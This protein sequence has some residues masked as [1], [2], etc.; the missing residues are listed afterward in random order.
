L[1]ERGFEIAGTRPGRANVQDRKDLWFHHPLR[2][3][4]LELHWALYVPSLHVQADMRGLWLRSQAIEIAG[5]R[6]VTLGFEDTL[7]Y[8]CV[9]GAV[10]RWSRLKWVCDVAAIMAAP[11]RIH[12]EQVLLRASRTGCRRMLLVGVNLAARILGTAVPPML[13]IEYERDRSAVV[14]ADAVLAD[15]LSNGS[16]NGDS[17]AFAQPLA[18]RERFRDRA[19]VL[20][21]KV[22]NKW[23]PTDEDRRA[24]RVPNAFW[25]L[26]LIIRPARL[27]RRYGLR[28][29]K[30]VFTGCS[31]FKLLPGDVSARLA[32]SITLCSGVSL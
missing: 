5:R 14:L 29:L 8:L 4:T 32:E 1:A 18:Y 2:S 11:A 10:H 13:A 12:W 19:L 16:I 21:S 24:I 25:P 31:A 20:C 30:V 15:V 26:Y 3:V 22:G 9:H 7:L 6:L 28:W 17:S 27:V 23:R